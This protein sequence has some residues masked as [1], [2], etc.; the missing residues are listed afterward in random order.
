MSGSNSQIS[1]SRIPAG[2]NLLIPGFFVEFDP[3]RAGYG[4]VPKRTMI[5]GQSIATVA[6]QPMFVQSVEWAANLFGP[7]AHLTRMIAAYR[8]NDAFGEVWCVPFAPAGGSTLAQGQITTGGSPTVN[9][10]IALCIGGF[11]VPVGVTAGMTP[12]QVAATIVAAI[13]ATQG[14]PVSAT[15]AVGVVTVVS[16]QPGSYGNDI[17]IEINTRGSRGAETTPAGLTVAVIAMA[18]GAGEPLLTGLDA[19]LGEEE[20]DYIAN[21][22]RGGASLDAAD[23]LLNDVT[24]RWAW[25]RQVYG[26]Y[27]TAIQN[28]SANLLT[29]GAGRNGR[30]GAGIGTDGSPTPAYEIAA[31]FAG[32]SAPSITAQPARPLQTLP[33]IGMRAPPPGRRFSAATNNALLNSGI[34]TVVVG[35]DGTC[36]IQRAV[37][38]YQRNAAGLVDRSYLDVE[39]G[40]T[41]M[42]ITRTLRAQV[43]GKYPRS[44]LASDGTRVGPGSNIVTPAIIRAELIVG[45]AALVDRGLAENEE[46][47]AAALVVQRD[48]QNPNRI[49]VLYPPDLMN[50][51]RQVAVLNQFRI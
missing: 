38:F 3:S 21:P 12:T 28:T 27:F 48:A 50:Q 43:Q 49:N 36:S 19:L 7:G 29:F 23:A 1:F 26:G 37:T 46:A 40:Y 2:S 32:A 11:D 44:L 39:T 15:S 4:A 6:S 45:Y 34:S 5:L 33:L 51:L 35:N 24:G 20:Y 31:M 16:L 18:G 8:R 22:W 25:N 47:F 42:E 9:A 30:A 14:I 17:T 10:Q 41:L 13:N